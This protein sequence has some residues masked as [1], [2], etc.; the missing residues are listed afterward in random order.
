MAGDSVQI[1]S[2]RNKALSD[3]AQ[4]T[5]LVRLLSVNDKMPACFTFDSG[6][7]ILVTGASGFIGN[8]LVACLLDRGFRNVC[9]L[10]RPSGGTG[11]SEAATKLGDSAVETIEGNLLSRDDCHNATQGVHVVYHLAAG[12]G[13]KS[14][15]D[16]Y[17]NSV[18]T[19]RNLLDACVQHGCLK[20][21][22]NVSSFAV[23]TNQN[24]PG[25]H[26]LDENCPVESQPAR[27]ANAYC[28]AKLRQEEMVSEYARKHGLSCVTLRPGWVYGPGNEAIHGRVGIGTFGLFLHLGGSNRVPLSYVDNCAEAIVLAGLADGVDGEVFNILDNDLPTSRQFLRAYKRKVKHF[29]SVYLPQELSYLACWLW[30]KAAAWSEGQ[31]PPIYGRA[32]W[33]ANWKRTKYSNEKLKHRLGWKQTVPTSE[34]LRRYFAAC[35][36]KAAIS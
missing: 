1:R 6:E 10:V 15:P 27:R 7:R 9:R 30:E 23:Y 33:H 32:A 19:T 34:G 4:R 21:F 24:K 13:E 25:G 31:L 22:V 35:R 28:F 14:F 18:V 36:E 5:K 20:R 26:L 8:R 17:A 3:W 11:S 12:R 2:L 29:R 16:A